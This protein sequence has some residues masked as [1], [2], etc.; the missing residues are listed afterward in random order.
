MPVASAGSNQAGGSDN[1]IVNHKRAPFDNVLVRR[2]ISMALDRHAWVQ[3]VRHGGAVISS[4]L[5]PRPAG[6]WGLSA[7]DLATVPGYRDPARDKADARRLLA[8][9]GFGPGKPL[10]AELATRTWGLQVDLAVWVQDQLRQVGIETTLK[11]MESAI[12]YPAI[13]RR[14]FTIAA[15]LTAVGV[16]DPDALLYEQYKCG[17]LRNAT[18]YCNPEVDRLIEL[19]SQEL[20]PKKRLTLVLQI[21][22]QL[23][24]DVGKPMLGWRNDYFAAWPSVKNL[25]PHYVIYTFGRMQEVW[26]DR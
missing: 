9:A 4:A 6:L 15:N 10:R 24:E 25:V 1:V 23:E 5:P 26:L 21:Q 3:A 2:A 18:D 13:A 16:D 12:W 22:R 8:E 17:S 20:D 11:Q 7:A 14:D 19:Q